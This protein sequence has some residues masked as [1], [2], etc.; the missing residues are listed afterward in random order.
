MGYRAQKERFLGKR[1][2]SNINNQ[3]AKIKR[4]QSIENFDEE[5]KILIAVEN[6]MKQAKNKRSNQRARHRSRH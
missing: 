1:Y 3:M 4:G 5:E 2:V 6:R